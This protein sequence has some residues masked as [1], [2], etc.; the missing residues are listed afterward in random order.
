MPPQFIPYTNSRQRRLEYTKPVCIH[1][2]RTPLEGLHVTCYFYKR[3]A[4][5]NNEERYRLDHADWNEY[6]ITS[7]SCP[8]ALT[9]TE[10]K[11]RGRSY[12]TLAPETRQILRAQK[13]G[14]TTFDYSAENNDE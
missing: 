10:S 1:E 6:P 13:R 8:V 9:Y 11:N 12:Y 14:S 7:V 3:V 5:P 4:G 2:D